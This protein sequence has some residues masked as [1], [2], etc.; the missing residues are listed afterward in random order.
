MVD[1]ARASYNTNGLEQILAHYNS[2][3]RV[4]AQRFAFLATPDDEILGYYY[5]V[6][7]SEHLQEL[8]DDGSS[9]ASEEGVWVT[10]EDVNHPRARSRTCAFD[11]SSTT[12]SLRLR[13]APRRGW[14]MRGRAI[15][16]R[17]GN[18]RGPHKR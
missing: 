9:R 18:E 8:L 17:S 2:P 1:E 6:D 13:L 15:R 5:A 7:F 4:D 3:N 11:S 12:G 10:H 14:Q 16:L